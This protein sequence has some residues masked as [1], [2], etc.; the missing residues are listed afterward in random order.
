VQLA[1]LSTDARRQEVI[2]ALTVPQP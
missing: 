2:A 1:E